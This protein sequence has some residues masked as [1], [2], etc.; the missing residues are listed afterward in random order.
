MAVFREFL[1]IQKGSM[2]VTK[3]GR[4]HKQ[5]Y[6]STYLLVDPIKIFSLAFS[7]KQTA[8]KFYGH[9]LLELFK[10]DLLSSRPICV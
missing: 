10:L 9:E 1:S 3:H 7:A 2:H 8:L 5:K 6:C 4:K